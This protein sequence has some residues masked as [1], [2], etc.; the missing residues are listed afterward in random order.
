MSGS[1]LQ[2]TQV[3]N[4]V[5]MLYSRVQ[6]IIRQRRRKQLKPALEISAPFDMKREPVSL[7]G[8]TEDEI[9][10]LREKAAASRIGIAENMTRSPI[11][12]RARGRMNT[13]FSASA[14]G[15]KTVSYYSY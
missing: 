3:K 15:N 14:V 13:T 6:T 4:N 8:I 9:S 1:S 12:Y 10:L 2:E 5:R 11:R 7:P